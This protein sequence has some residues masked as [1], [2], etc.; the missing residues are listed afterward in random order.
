[1]RIDSTNVNQSDLRRCLNFVL[2]LTGK[3]NQ[4]ASNLQFDGRENC[5]VYNINK[6]I[7]DGMT[8]RDYKQMIKQ[9]FHEYDPQ[10][11]LIKHLKYVIE[12]GFI[13]LQG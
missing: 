6:Y 7:I 8:V 13:E 4:R 9:R 5:S 1:M 3:S 12:K 10:F 2:R 11:S